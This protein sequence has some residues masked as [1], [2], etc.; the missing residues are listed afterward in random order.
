MCKH[1]DWL[2]ISFVANEVNA[3]LDEWN[4]AYYDT[5]PVTESLET[6]A[7]SEVYMVNDGYVAP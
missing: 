4:C 1:G 6:S 5:H 7:S 2:R 3:L